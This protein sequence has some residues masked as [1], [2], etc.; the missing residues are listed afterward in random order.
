MELPLPA[1]PAAPHGDAPMVG[2]PVAMERAMEPPAA[3]VG[4]VIVGQP[5]A[6]GAGSFGRLRRL[7]VRR[8]F[9]S[10]RQCP[11]LRQCPRRCSWCRGL[12]SREESSGREGALC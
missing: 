9:P 12:G 3:A 11:G 8:Q 1:G 2:A 6:A 7:R 4:E 5:V 10:C